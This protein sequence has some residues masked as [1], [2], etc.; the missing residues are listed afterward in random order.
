MIARSSNL[1]ELSIIIVSFNCRELVLGCLRSIDVDPSNSSYQ[2]IVVDNASTDTTAEAVEAMYPN[3]VLVRSEGN[4]GFSVAS[5]QGMDIA[6]GRHLLLLNPDTR[7]PP[8]ALAAAVA[9]LNRRPEVGMLGVK[10]VKEDGK[11]DHAAKR[12]FPTPLSA[13]AYFLRLARLFPQSRIANGYT[14]AHIHDDEVSYVDAVNGAFMLVRRE[15]VVQ[16]GPLDDAYWLY[17]EDLDWCYRFWQAGWPVLYWPEV[18][19]THI[20][21]GSSGRYRS[22]VANRAFHRGMWLFY[23]KHYAARKSPLTSALVYCG[24]HLKLWISLSNARLHRRL[25]LARSGAE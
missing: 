6:S 20:K 1:P 12:G 7:V 11:P 10:L 19:I 17:M 22:S 21:A 2:I 8:G 4:N 16:V 25:A 13:L 23:K 15:A 14:A 5:N 9:E 3:V 18:S 24:I